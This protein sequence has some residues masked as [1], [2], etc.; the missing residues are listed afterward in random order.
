LVAAAEQRIAFTRYLLCDVH[1][2][3]VPLAE[4]DAGL[5]AVQDGARSQDEALQRRE[6]SPQ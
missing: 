6:R 2:R 5:R 3:Q 4:V 1:V